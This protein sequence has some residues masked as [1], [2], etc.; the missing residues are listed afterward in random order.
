[1][2]SALP[3]ERLDRNN[4]FHRGSTRCI[5][6]FSDKVIGAT[7]KERIKIN[8]AQWLPNTKHGIK[9]QDEQCIVWQRVSMTTCLAT[10]MKPRRRRK[11]GKI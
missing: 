5:N 9:P 8:L 10:F 4:I 11:H 1:M 6:T 2:G 7:S 3:N